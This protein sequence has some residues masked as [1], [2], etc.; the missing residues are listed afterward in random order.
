MSNDEL[1]IEKWNQIYFVYVHSLPVYRSFGKNACHFDWITHALLFV[2]ISTF[3]L[4]PSPP[5]PSTTS[6][7]DPSLNFI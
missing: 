2:F 6:E 3:S 1:S 4:N 7:G 5:L